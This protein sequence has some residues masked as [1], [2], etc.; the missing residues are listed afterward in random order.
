MVN[1]RR[2]CSYKLVLKFEAQLLLTFPAISVQAPLLK[3]VCIQQKPSISLTHTP[4]FGRVLP[5][6]LGTGHSTCCA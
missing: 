2:L 3:Q 1:D 4:V 6:Y 5:L